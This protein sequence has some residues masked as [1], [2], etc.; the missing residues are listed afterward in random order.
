M[1][2]HSPAD[3]AP[4]AG[5]F[6]HLDVLTAFMWNQKSTEYP[7]PSSNFS[8]VATRQAGDGTAGV[9]K[10]TPLLTSTGFKRVRHRLLSRHRQPA[11][12]VA[13][14]ALVSQRMSGWLQPHVS[15]AENH[16]PDL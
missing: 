10:S 7:Q 14:E 8:F 15:L 16:R 9:H 5:R 1:D 4:A 2:T 11:L 13:S 3:E 12:P 6:V